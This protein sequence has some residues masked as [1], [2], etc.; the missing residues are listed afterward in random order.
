MEEIL[1][2]KENGMEEGKKMKWKR[3]WKK[4]RGG[5]GNDREQGKW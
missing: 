4:L 5:G 1:K 3:K 2:E